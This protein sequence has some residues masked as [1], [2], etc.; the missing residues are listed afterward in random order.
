MSKSIDRDEKGR[1][2]KGNQ[3]ALSGWKALLDKRFGGDIY[4][5]KAWMKRIGDYGYGCCFKDSRTG[6]FPEWVKDC[7]KTE[8]PP[9]ETFKNEFA[10]K[11][12]FTMQDVGELKF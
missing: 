9:L 8:P 10:A 3:T 5:A 6:E 7:F 2:V 1:F 11:L 12:E 4:M